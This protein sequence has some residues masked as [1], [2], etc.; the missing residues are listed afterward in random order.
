MWVMVSLLVLCFLLGVSHA[1][2]F[3]RIIPPHST[4]VVDAVTGKP[5][6]GINVCIPAVS[7]GWGPQALQS[8]LA[9]T[10]S[11]GRALFG[12]SVLNLALLQSF[13]GYSMQITDPASQFADTCGPHVGLRPIPIGT[14]AGDPFIDAR[15]DG[16]EHFPLELVDSEELAT[17]ISWSSFTRGESFRSFMKISLVP[18]LNDP[19]Q[20]RQ[21]IDPELRQECARLNHIAQDALPENL[22]PKYFRGMQRATLQTFDGRSAGSRFYYAVYESHS[23]PAQYTMVGIERFPKGQ[24]ASEH[25]QD[26]PRITPNCDLTDAVEEEPIPGERIQRIR[27][28]QTPCAFWSSGNKLIM[29]QFATPSPFKRSSVSEW[30]MRHP[31]S[32]TAR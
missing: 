28:T 20:C 21:V 32:A 22:V 18:L 15:M 30:L 11:G 16:T 8:D 1:L 2:L 24:N 31:A 10:G 4:R 19:D 5:I 14:H 7:N 13:D 26:I 23:T 25:F 3:I 27:S 17:N 6:S 9:T 12:P 29:I